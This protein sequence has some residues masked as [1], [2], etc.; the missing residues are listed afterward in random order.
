MSCR[1]TSSCVD[2][3][4][5]FTLIELLVSIAVIGLLMALL[6]PAVQ[7][8]REIGAPHGMHQQPEADW[9]GLP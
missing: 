5:A 9:S 6:L 2:R 1:Q 7:M 3:R 8:A 4:S